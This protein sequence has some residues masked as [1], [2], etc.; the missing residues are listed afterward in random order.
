MGIPYRQNK[1]DFPEPH[2]QFEVKIQHVGEELSIVALNVEDRTD[3][4]EIN[5]QGAEDVDNVL[6]KFEHNYLLIA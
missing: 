5:V 1:Q 4:F 6:R 3:F 2:K